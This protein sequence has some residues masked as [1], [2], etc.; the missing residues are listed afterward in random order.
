[1]SFR[2]KKESGAKA[3]QWGAFCQANWQLIENIGLPIATIETLD[4]FCDL[5]MHGYLESYNDPTEFRLWKLKPENLKLFSVLVD[6]YFEAGFDNPGMSP[7]EV[8]GREEYLRLVRKY[9][10]QFSSFDIAEAMEQ[11][12]EEQAGEA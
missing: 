12:R 10:D 6:R 11:D 1:M 8:G 3:R 4:G 5:L 7:A 2:R 9:P